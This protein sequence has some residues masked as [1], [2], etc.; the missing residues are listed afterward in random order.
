MQA[1]SYWYPVEHGGGVCLLTHLKH[2]NT[3]SPV[4]VNQLRD[5]GSYH[6]MECVNAGNAPLVTKGK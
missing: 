2:L 6:T 1:G 3:A 4:E 5:G